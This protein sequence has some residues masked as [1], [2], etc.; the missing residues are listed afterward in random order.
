MSLLFDKF[1]LQ[2][3][4]MFPLHLL[5]ETLYQVQVLYISYIHVVYRTNTVRSLHF[6]R[7]VS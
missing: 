3:N 6:S 5:V 4:P 1:S 7:N 2:S